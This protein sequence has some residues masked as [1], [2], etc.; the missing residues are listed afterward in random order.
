MMSVV[1][2]WCQRWWFLDYLVKRPLVSGSG[3]VEVMPIFGE[4]KIRAVSG[5]GLTLVAIGRAKT[6]KCYHLERS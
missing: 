2:D 4:K 1:D 3:S 6:S 5:K